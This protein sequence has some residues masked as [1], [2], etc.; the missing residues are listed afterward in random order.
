MATK[1]YESRETFTSVII[2]VN[3][4]VFI[5]VFFF[6]LFNL[7]FVLHPR[8]VVPN[9]LSQYWGGCEAGTDGV[10]YFTENQHKQMK[11]SSQQKKKHFRVAKLS[12]I[13]FLSSVQSTKQ[14][15]EITVQHFPV[16]P[17]LNNQIYSLFPP[18]NQL[19]HHDGDKMIFFHTSRNSFLK[20]RINIS[21]T[22]GW[23]VN[24]MLDKSFIKLSCAGKMKN[25]WK[26]PQRWKFFFRPP[27][28][29]CARRVNAG[30][31]F[32]SSLS[33]L[34]MISEPTSVDIWAALE[35]LFPDAQRA[36]PSEMITE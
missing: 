10:E 5:R 11:F 1:N 18:F 27:A 3:T 16:A 31:H 14:I 17:H 29:V 6:C 24:E 34:C 30:R 7:L 28:G 12:V 13:F 20:H 23:G 15:S 25:S 26:F 2:L 19:L 36:S 4:K 9:L 21:F 35:G 22:V 8:R 33:S 32:L